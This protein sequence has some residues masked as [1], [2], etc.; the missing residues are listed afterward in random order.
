MA[1]DIKTYQVNL[2]SD[3]TTYIQYDYNKTKEF[4]DKVTRDIDINSVS[5]ATV[6][7]KDQFS[8]VN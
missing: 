5:L 8:E 3:C 6:M 7:N 4:I 2:P 1:G